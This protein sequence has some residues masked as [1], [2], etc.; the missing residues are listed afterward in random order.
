[1]VGAIYCFLG[2]SSL[3]TIAD[4]FQE[5]EEYW[6]EFGKTIDNSG[7]IN[8]DCYDDIIV[9]APAEGT[10]QQ[11]KV[12]IYSTQ[13]I[14]SVQEEKIAPK[15]FRLL[16]N[17]P[18]PFNTMTKINFILDRNSNIRLVIYDYIGKTVQTLIEGKLQPGSHSIVWTPENLPSGLYLCR[19][20]VGSNTQ[21]KKLLLLK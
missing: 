9:S 2:G 1:M 15:Y 16:Q 5:G 21:T 18:N 14:S 3:D 7:D 6:S 11:A 17:Y 8:C 13:P 10:Q 19:L 20:S 4:F 12:Y